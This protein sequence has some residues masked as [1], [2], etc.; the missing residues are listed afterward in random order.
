MRE[1][2][3]DRQTNA[4]MIR[5][6]VASPGGRPGSVAGGF[7]SAQRRSSRQ[8]PRWD[9]NPRITDLQSVPLVHLGT[10]PRT[11]RIRP[12]GRIRNVFRGFGRSGGHPCS[13]SPAALGRWLHRPAAVRAASYHE[14]NQLVSP[15]VSDRG[16]LGGPRPPRRPLRRGR[17]TDQPAEA[18]PGAAR[19]RGG[20]SPAAARPSPRPWRS[21][22]SCRRS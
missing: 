9:S 13:P 10:R 5:W 8:R 14:F 20:R 21:S 2:A 19:R 11:G 6:S 4:P 1:T 16:S 22:S 18:A 7:S 12:G 17:R 3:T 15:L